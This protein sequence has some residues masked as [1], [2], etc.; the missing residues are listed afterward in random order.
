MRV[1]DSFYLRS[2]FFPPA[3]ETA[4]DQAKD[5]ETA[6]AKREG[7][8]AD[9]DIKAK[10]DELPSVPTTDPADADHVQKKQKQESED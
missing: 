2:R 10:A 3:S 1:S 4:A 6:S 7:F 8:K 5:E 9:E